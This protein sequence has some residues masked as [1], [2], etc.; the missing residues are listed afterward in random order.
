MSRASSRK[1]RR[2]PTEY[3]NVFYPTAPVFHNDHIGVHGH[4]VKVSPRLEKRLLSD[5]ITEKVLAMNQEAAETAKVLCI[6]EN[7]FAGKEEGK[8]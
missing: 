6:A 4:H 5:H 1:S 8:S 3:D 7:F 2:T